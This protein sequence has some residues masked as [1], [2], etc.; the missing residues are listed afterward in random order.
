MPSYPL[1]IAH[2]NAPEACLDSVAGLRKAGTPLRIV[3]ADNN[4]EPEKRARLRRGLP[5]DVE[6]VEIPENRGFGG[7]LNVLL[8]RWLGEPSEEE[9]CFLASHDVMP[10]KDCLE[11]LA[12]AMLSDR[13]IG[14]AC[15]DQDA[16]SSPVYPHFSPVL[17]PRSIRCQ[18]GGKGELKDVVFANAT[19][20]AVR[21]RCIRDLDLF[22]DERFF[23][24]GEEYDFGLRASRAGWRVVL[25]WG[26]TVDNPGRVAPSL[27]YSYL[28][29]RN[30]LFLAL[31]YGGAVAA[32]LRASLFLLNTA[33]LLCFDAKN[34]RVGEFGRGRARALIDFLRGRYG[35]PPASLSPRWRAVT[36]RPYQE[37]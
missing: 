3:I 15:P 11:L 1:F 16:E 22:F 26:A 13:S 2:W 29:G 30:S 31:R 9:F 18:P 32:A 37:G 23:C 25:V 35:P 28:H 14:I 10:R 4:S 33:R 5:Q 21:R 17:G 12:Q 36:W 8:H 19:L 6:L 24:Y 7:A 20:F 34:H 27:L